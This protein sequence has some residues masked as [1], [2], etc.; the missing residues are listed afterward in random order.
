MIPIL[1]ESTESTYQNN[2]IGRLADAISVVCDEQLNG[3]YELNM[4]YP[5]N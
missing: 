1:Y 5:A 2:G 3:V 4:V